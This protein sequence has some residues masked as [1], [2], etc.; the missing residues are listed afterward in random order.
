M[1]VYAYDKESSR[2]SVMICKLGTRGKCARTSGYAKREMAVCAV[3]RREGGHL[4]S[5]ENDEGVVVLRRAVGV[6]SVCCAVIGFTCV[7]ALGSA[8][9]L[10]PSSLSLPEGVMSNTALATD[11]HG[12]A[13]VV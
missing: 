6:I 5:W 11:P 3:S 13:A 1:R 2:T 10:A 9:W 8:A 7:P 4:L 12:D